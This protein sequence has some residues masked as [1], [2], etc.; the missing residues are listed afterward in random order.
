MG[1]GRV[2]VCLGVVCVPTCMFVSVWFLCSGSVYVFVSVPVYVCCVSTC[3]SLCV[4][5]SVSV[6]VCGGVSDVVY[7]FVCVFVY[8]CLGVGV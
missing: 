7:V 4:S 5:V 1:G 3:V 8:V 6:C 2:C